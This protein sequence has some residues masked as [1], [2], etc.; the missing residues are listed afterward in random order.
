MKQYSVTVEGVETAMRI[1]DYLKRRLGFSTSLIAKVKYDNVLLNGTPVHMRAEVKNGDRIDVNFPD[2]ESESIE[3]IDIPIDVIYEDEYILLVNKPINMPIHP[4]QG[5]HLPTLANAVCAYLGVPFV[6]RSITRLDRDTAGIVLIAKDQLSAARLSAE[7][8]SGG[9][10]KRY[11]ATVEGIPSP[12]CGR[13]DAPIERECEGSIK[14]VVRE[15]GKPSI[16]E[17]EVISEGADGTSQVSL[18][19]ITGR[20]H[21]LRVHMAYI[22]HPL[23]GD[24]LYGERREGATYSLTCVELSFTHPYSGERMTISI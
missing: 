24:F 17:Y 5:N 13:I 14:R 23:V 11:V 16:S 1:R 20:T 7:M 22:G 15:G 8:K 19:P 6:Y 3:P 18:V 9:I 12:R 10:K 21:Q 2:E 4:S